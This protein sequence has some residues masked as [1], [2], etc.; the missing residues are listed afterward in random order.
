MY[1]R[2][3]C[4]LFLI[5]CTSSQAQQV[6]IYSYYIPGLIDSPESGVMVDMLNKIERSTKIDFKLKLLPTKR[7]QANFINNKIVG[8]FPELE[9]NR[10]KSSC[11]TD[12]FMKKKIIAITRKGEPKV[13]S[14][15]DL[16]GKRIGGV[17][18]FSYG[19]LITK[20]GDITLSFVDND[21]KNIKKLLSNRIDVIIGDAHS[22]INAINEAGSNDSVY[23]DL[24]NPINIID[25]FFVFQNTDEGQYFCKKVS[26]S[27]EE[28]RV[29]GDLLLWFG[30][31]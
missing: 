4:F 10:P 14:I 16:L 2:L 9:E 30:Y 18:G 25:V 15:K 21:K 6:D 31:Q 20:N 29:E 5:F 3:V 7:V 11:R 8:Y 17:K 24:N 1:N 22:T 27:I 28:L 19:N 23:Y 26:S 13:T 12:S